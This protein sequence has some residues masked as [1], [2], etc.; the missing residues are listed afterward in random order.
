MHVLRP[1]TRLVRSAR[2]YAVLR[3]PVRQHSFSR[4]RLVE[5]DGAVAGGTTMEKP[6]ELPCTERPVNRHTHAEIA[7]GHIERHIPVNSAIKPLIIGVGGEK[8][9]RLEVHKMTAVEPY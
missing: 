4:W 5:H 3:I 9:R 7:D 8:L 6:K 1:G 2:Y